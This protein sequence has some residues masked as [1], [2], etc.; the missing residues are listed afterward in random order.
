MTLL[1]NARNSTHDIDAIFHPSQDMRE[2]IKEIADENELEEDWLNDG[3]KGFMN[4]NM[5]TQIIEKYRNLYVY[6]YRCKRFIG[7]E[8]NFCKNRTNC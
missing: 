4:N 5:K 3:V 1:F 8:I 7:N 6:S 2:I